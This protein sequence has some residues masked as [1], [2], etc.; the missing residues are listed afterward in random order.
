MTDYICSQC[1]A[2]YTRKCDFMRH[3]KKSHDN[4]C[5]RSYNS[6]KGINSHE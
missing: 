5:S 6:T 4:T 1:N 3:F 2:K